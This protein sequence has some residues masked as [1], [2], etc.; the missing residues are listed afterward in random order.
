MFYAEK[1]ASQDKMIHFYVYLYLTV[2]TNQVKS[3]D[4]VS[5]TLKHKMK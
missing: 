3:L 4:E 5:S 1:K 2:L